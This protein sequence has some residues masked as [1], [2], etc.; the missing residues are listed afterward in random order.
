MHHPNHGMLGLLL[1]H[2][3]V[4]TYTVAASLNSLVEN[5][6]NLVTHPPYSLDLALCDWFLI[7]FIKQQLQGGQ[8]QSLECAQAYFEGVSFTIP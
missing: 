2:D 5:S 4:G 8:F 7:S 1:H 6:T 3:N